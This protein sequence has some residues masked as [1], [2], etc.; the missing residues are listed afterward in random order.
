MT[1][2]TDRDQNRTRTEPWPPRQTGSDA[3]PRTGTRASIDD[4]GTE[5]SPTK[6]DHEGKQQ[7]WSEWL[8]LQFVGDADPLIR[9]ELP[10]KESLLDYG[11]NGEQVAPNGFLRR[12]SQGWARIGVAQTYSLNARAFVWQRWLRFTT[13]VA[14]LVL[15]NLLIPGS[16]PLWVWAF[17]IGFLI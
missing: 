8:R 5:A 1:D 10:T 3:I 14:L 9:T 11:D 17:L 16:T 15:I 4:F 13:A 7:G 6:S 12:M 2:V